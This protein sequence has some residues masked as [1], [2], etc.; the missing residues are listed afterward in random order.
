MIP[1]GAA[2]VN[3]KTGEPAG[4]PAFPYAIWVSWGKVMLLSQP[5]MSCV[6]CCS[7]RYSSKL[8]GS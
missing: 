8:R 3:K 6:N 2:I 1:A 7:L 4:S 5:V